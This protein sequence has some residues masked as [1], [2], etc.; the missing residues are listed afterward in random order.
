MFLLEAGTGRGSMF[1]GEGEDFFIYFKTVVSGSYTTL[2]YWIPKI[3]NYV[4]ISTYG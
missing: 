1:A 3:K 2:L 4:L